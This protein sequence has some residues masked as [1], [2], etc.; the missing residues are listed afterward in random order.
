MKRLLLPACL[1]LLLGRGLTQPPV[2]P[3]DS[4]Q[5][6][7]KTHPG[8][9]SVRVKLLIDLIKAVIYTAPDEAM[10]YSDEILRISGKLDWRSGT[11]FGYRYKGLVYYLNGDYLNALDYLQKSLGA[12]ESLHNKKFDA[13]MFNNLAIVYMELKQYAKAMSYYQKYL[14]A[15]RELGLTE[16]EAKALLNIGNCYGETDDLDN[17]LTYCKQS[18]DLAEKNNYPLVTASAL[19]SLAI[20]Y[21]RKKDYP[22]S[23]GAFQK[24]IALSRAMG[25]LFNEATA[26]NGIAQVYILLQDYTKAENYADDGLAVSKQIN[27]LKW[28]DDSWSTLSDIYSHQHNYA[29]ALDAYKNFTSLHDSLSNDEKKQNFTRKD[30][31]YEYDKKEALLKAAN[32]QRQAL[33]AAEIGRQRVIRNSVIGGSAMLLLASIT[34]LLFYK[35]RRDAE[36]LKKEAEFKARVSDTEMKALRSQINPHFIFNSLNSINDYI[37]RN[38]S[39]KASEYLV[40]FAGIMRMILEYSEK[41]EIS[42]ADDLKALELYIQLEALRLKGKFSYEIRLDEDIDIENTQVPPLMLQP[43][44]ENSIWHGLARKEGEGKISIRISRQNEMIKY[45]IE[46]NGI[47]R[48]KAA[49]VAGTNPGGSTER[50]GAARQ[51]MGMKITGE[52]I[53][54]INQVRN[55]GASIHLSDLEQGTRVEVLLPLELNS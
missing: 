47:G 19:N 29:K 55:A 42:L 38:D 53:A 21:K 3:A 18:L 13:S 11:A 23:I 25:N 14:A 20:L 1:A 6:L 28:E 52:R 51:S 5:T 39:R 50:S 36:E 17:A 43:F 41:K 16:E 26:L 30:L 31:Q 45:A 35:R 10:K 9:D 46:D 49:L 44:V 40:K 32:D 15:S 12:A 37:S 8:E 33:A 7:L 34:S 22:E 27:A 4:I 2:R 48:V 54:I 24:S